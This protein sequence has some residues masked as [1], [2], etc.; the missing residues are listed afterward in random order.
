MKR[1]NNKGFGLVEVLVIL[2][3]LTFV[4]DIS[5]PYIEKEFN[6]DKE[7]RSAQEAICILNAQT[8]IRSLDNKLLFDGVT[9]GSYY[10][11]ELTVPLSDS[12]PTE[13]SWVTIENNKVVKACM[14]IKTENDQILINYAD[15]VYDA[16]D[17]ILMTK[18]E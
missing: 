12:T 3:M 13:Y 9:N 7:E 14:L 15:G 10:V 18:P 17:G 6:L 2:A 8:Y 1:L 11:T 16:S 4:I 5:Y